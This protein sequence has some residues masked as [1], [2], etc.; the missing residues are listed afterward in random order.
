MLSKEIL[1]ELEQY[2]E[3]S[4]NSLTFSLHY[5]EEANYS[6]LET[7]QNIELED[8]VKNRR[9]PTLR[10]VLFSYI[11]QIGATD[12]EIYKKAGIDRKLFSKIRTNENYRP[13]KNTIIAL[14][15]A[16]ELERDDA[17]DLLGAA[18]YSLSESETFDLVIQFCFEK[19]IYNLLD[20]N[21]ALDYFSLK[22]LSGA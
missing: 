16:L 18:G 6:I 14:A 13:G 17:D 22:P 4:L 3:M 19:S 21:E 20:V 7:E 12:A 8:F 11:D 2:V 5:S 15:L 1:L 9:K 10:E